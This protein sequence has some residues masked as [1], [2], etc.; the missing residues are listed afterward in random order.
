MARKKMRKFGEGDSVTSDDLEAANASADPIGTLN[1]RKG[2]TGEKAEAA[3]EPKKQSFGEAF[4]AARKG[5]GK[6]F[7]WNGKKYT[8]EMAGEKKAAPAP[9]PAA[10]K[11]PLRAETMQDRA[12]SYVAK[13]AAQREADRAAAEAKR[14]TDAETARLNKRAPASYKFDS[15]KVNSK[16]LLPKGMKKGGSVRGWGIARSARKAKI[17]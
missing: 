9:A 13:R 7:E 4:A 8:T 11:A 16:T 17:V 2:W 5:G 1:E 6:T 10:P 3:P 12:E 14:D 15:S